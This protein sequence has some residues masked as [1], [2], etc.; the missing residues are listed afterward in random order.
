MLNMKVFVDTDDDVRLA[1][2][3]Q[4]DVTFRGRDVAGM[5]GVAGMLVVAEGLLLLKAC[6]PS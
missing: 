1:R 6:L 4:R 5:L 2:R 3:I